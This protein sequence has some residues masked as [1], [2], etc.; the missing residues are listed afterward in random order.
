VFKNTQ[1]AMNR[2]RE[3]LGLEDQRRIQAVVRE[4]SLAPLCPELES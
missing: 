2:W 1:A 3:E 4:T